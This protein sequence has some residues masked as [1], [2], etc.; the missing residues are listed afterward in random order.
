MLNRVILIGRLTKDIELRYTTSGTAV[1]NMTLAVD[2]YKKEDGADFI[3][4]V[5]WQK[6]AE[7]CAKYIGKGR[8]IAVDGRLQ[9][10]VYEAADGTNRK[11]TEV[12]A[13]NVKF[14]DKPKEASSE[15]LGGEIFNEEDQVPF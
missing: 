9:T 15:V 3:N 11:V 4:C 10:R 13:E 2:K 14:L 12:V 7:N 5:V 1:A 6:T 8:L